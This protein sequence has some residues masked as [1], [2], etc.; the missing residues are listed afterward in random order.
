MVRRDAGFRITGGKGF[1]VTF[2]NG[3]TV[4]VQFGCFNYCANRSDA[5]DLDVH[6]LLEQDKLA[7][8][9]GSVTAE[10]AVWGPD[11]KPGAGDWCMGDRAQGWPPPAHVLRLMTWAA[12]QPIA[13]EVPS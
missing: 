11:G 9:R 12:A 5:F 4:S 2:D 8:G 7:A 10:T 3:W 1:H 13:G 6:D